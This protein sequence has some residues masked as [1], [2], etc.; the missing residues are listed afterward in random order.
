MA[1]KLCSYG[2]Y[3]CIIFYEHVI[4]YY[5]SHLKNLIPLL[6]MPVI[7]TFQIWEIKHAYLKGKINHTFYLSLEG[8]NLFYL[9]AYEICH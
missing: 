7:H 4:Q 9:C 8:K 3:A 2:N 5:S 6:L 1:L